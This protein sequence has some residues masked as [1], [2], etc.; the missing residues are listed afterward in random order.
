MLPI[1][2]LKVYDSL[3]N[4]KL[5]FRSGLVDTINIF[6]TYVFHNPSTKQNKNNNN[7]QKIIII[8]SYFAQDFIFD[9]LTIFTIFL[10]RS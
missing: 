3:F 6:D 5:I 4:Q 10:T 2:E 1:P 9:L 8:I 7:T